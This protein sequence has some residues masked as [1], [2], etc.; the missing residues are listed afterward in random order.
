MYPKEGYEISPFGGGYNGAELYTGSFELKAVI[1]PL[2]D[3]HNSVV[4]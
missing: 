2:L 1:R 4:K 3:T